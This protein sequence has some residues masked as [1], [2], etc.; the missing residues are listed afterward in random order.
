[1]KRIELRIG[2]LDYIIEHVSEEMRSI[3]LHKSN[4]CEYLGSWNKED[5]EQ[6]VS[7]LFQKLANRIN[8]HY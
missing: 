2:L 3:Y 7:Y 8:T 4:G 6:E 5:F 1:M